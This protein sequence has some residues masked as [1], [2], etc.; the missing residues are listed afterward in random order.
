MDTPEDQALQEG[1]EVVR[2]ELGKMRSELSAVADKV[3]DILADRGKETYSKARATATAARQRA[4][5]ASDSASRMIE[6]RPLVSVI[7]AFFI[8]LV[9]GATVLAAVPARQDDG[10]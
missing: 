6:D 2:A 7:A 10:R 4:E 3:K 9:V 1:A 8:G 5:V